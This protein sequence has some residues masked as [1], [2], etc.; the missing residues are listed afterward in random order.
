MPFG[1]TNGFACF[2]RSMDNFISEEKLDYT[3]A[4]MDNIT[5]YGMSKNNDDENLVKFQ[6]EANCRNLTFK[7]DKCTF[8]TTSLNFIGY[9][10]S[11]GEIKPDVERLKPL[12]D[13]PIPHGSKS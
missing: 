4:F 9:N 2:Q 10:I 13:L 6:E 3:V 7:K 11:Q 5:K 8:Q 12:R 1:V